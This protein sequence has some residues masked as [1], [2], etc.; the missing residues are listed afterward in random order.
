MS[1]EDE[2]YEVVLAN[3]EY[4]IQDRAS[5]PISF[6]AT[7]DPGTMYWHQAMQQPNKKEFLKAAEA[8]VKSHV[9]N[10]HFVLMERS[11]LPR[12]TKVLSWV[13]S[14]KQKRRILSRKIYKWKAR[15]TAMEGSRIMA[16]TSGKRTRQW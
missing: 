5:D 13:W 9:D 10:K 16:S 1:P 8:E 6:L 2:I 12:G 3:Q 4:G 15:Q 11:S 14:M 7:S